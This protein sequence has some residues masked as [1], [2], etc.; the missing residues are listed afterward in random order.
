MQT[1]PNKLVALLLSLLLGLLPLQN[2]F[3][4]DTMPMAHEMTSSMEADSMAGHPMDELAD[5]DCDDCD[6]QSCCEQSSC[7]LHHCASCALSAV[8]PPDSLFLERSSGTTLV[9]LQQSLPA[10]RRSSLFRPPRS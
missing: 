8:I 5:S 6:A 3:A 7:S 4:S 9:G 10:N 1:R 2:L